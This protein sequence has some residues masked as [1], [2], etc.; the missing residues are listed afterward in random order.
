VPELEARVKS[1]ETAL[2]AEKA[3]KA[4]ALTV[5]ESRL[6]EIELSAREAERKVE[7]AEAAVAAAGTA[8]VAAAAAPGMVTEAEAREAAVTWLRGQIG[9]LRQEI[10]QQTASD[11]KEGS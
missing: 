10:G 1:L 6:K 9:A 11:S 5:A 8:P 2:E 3:S 7:E 4:E